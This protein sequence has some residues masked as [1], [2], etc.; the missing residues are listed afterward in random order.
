MKID[1]LVSML[2]GLLHVEKKPKLVQIIL[3]D[4]GFSLLL[5]NFVTQE[6]F[7][8]CAIPI[9]KEI[10]KK[11]ENGKVYDGQLMS[12]LN[13]VH[14]AL[15]SRFIKYENIVSTIRLYTLGLGRTDVSLWTETDCG[16]IWLYLKMGTTI[17]K[18]V[19]HILIQ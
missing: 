12:L 4:Y 2:K 15:A 3:P 7:D 18:T 13:I 5:Q 14:L 19:T 11:I 9:C 6:T 10:R 16:V 8:N 17:K 1:G